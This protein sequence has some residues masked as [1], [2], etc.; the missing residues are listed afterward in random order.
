[1]D[2]FNIEIVQ[3]RTFSRDF[4]S[5]AQ[6]AFLVNEAA[7]KAAEWESP[8]GQEINLWTG[9]TARIVGVMKDFHMHSLH[10][11]IEPVLLALSE[12]QYIAYLSIKI[13][14]VNTSATVDFVKVVMKRISPDYPFE[15]SFFDDVFERADAGAL[16][17]VID[18]GASDTGG[19]AGTVHVG[20]ARVAV[21]Q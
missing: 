15:F 14:P 18:A 6:G 2:F 3:G 21:V 11:P 12:D 9:G 17:R 7:V 16:G 20:F 10:R 5:D 13:K 8:I 19:W 4:P 1:M